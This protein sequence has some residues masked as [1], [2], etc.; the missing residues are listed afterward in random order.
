MTFQLIE[1]LA[2]AGA[3]FTSKQ[4]DALAALTAVLCERLPLYFVVGH[5]HIAQPSGRKCDPGPTF[6]WEYFK[7]LLEKKPQT[8]KL[9][10]TFL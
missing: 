5:E 2:A 10:F 4:Y 8:A 7:S 1:L 9:N 3:K 6:E